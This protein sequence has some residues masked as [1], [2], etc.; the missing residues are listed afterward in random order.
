MIAAF[1]L[2]LL[3]K[4]KQE[5]QGVCMDLNQHSKLL[6]GESVWPM[7]MSLSHLVSVL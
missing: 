1:N 4:R 2:K 3:I 5:K 7:A 6:I